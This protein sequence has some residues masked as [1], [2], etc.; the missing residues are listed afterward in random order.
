MNAKNLEFFM[1]KG[2]ISFEPKNYLGSLV[3]LIYVEKYNDKEIIVLNWNCSKG[4]S[5]F[6]FHLCIS[7][8]QIYDQLAADPKHFR[9]MF[10]GQ[11]KDF[12]E[13]NIFHEGVCA[14]FNG[15]PEKWITFAVAP[16]GLRDG[17][18]VHFASEIILVGE[19]GELIRPATHVQMDEWQN[20]TI[21]LRKHTS[22][23]D[24]MGSDT[25]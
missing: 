8:D 12:P 21:E 20:A 13:D 1:D 19:G 2:V 4:E 18:P 16:I 9:P 11:L 23:M 6:E 3:P 14:M 7:L 17:I 10:I 25:V 5:Q 22:S 15:D 24:W